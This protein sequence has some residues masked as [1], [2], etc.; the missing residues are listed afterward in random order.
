MDTLALDS[1]TIDSIAIFHQDHQRPKVP[2]CLPNTEA[3]VENFDEE[4]VL[5]AEH[6]LHNEAKMFVSKEQ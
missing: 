1:S 3:P 4:C 2:P 5:T 6:L